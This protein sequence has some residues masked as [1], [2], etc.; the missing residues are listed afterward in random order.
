MFIRSTTLSSHCRVLYHLFF[1]FFFSSL[2]CLD[3]HFPSSPT[4]SYTML[5][6][7]ATSSLSVFRAAPMRFTAAR[8]MATEAEGGAAVNEELVFNLSVPDRSLVAGKEVTR[9]TLPGRAGVFGVEKNMPPMVSE[10]RPGA[11]MVEY[12]SS[13]KEEF[14]IPVRPA[15]CLFVYLS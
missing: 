6:R 8:C 15:V 2:P 7:A 12:T 10:L 9:V 5:S 4:C 1:F 3:T 14:F 11:I 13:E